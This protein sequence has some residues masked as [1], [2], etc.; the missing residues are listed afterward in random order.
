V[1]YAEL[2]LRFCKVHRHLELIAASSR[3]GLPDFICWTWAVHGQLLF[4]KQMGWTGVERLTLET[5][6]VR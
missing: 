3:C 6:H 4:I 5:V 1:E 2:V